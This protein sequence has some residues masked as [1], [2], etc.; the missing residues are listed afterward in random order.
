MTASSAPQFYAAGQYTPEQSIGYLM[1]KLISSIL[2]QADA[3][4]AQ[5]KLTYVQWLPL[6]KLLTCER[7]TLASLS[8]DL[9]VDPAALTRSISRL[10]AKGL[11]RR[12]RSTQ[13]RRVVHLSLTEEGRS[14]A[15]HVPG[16]L[17]D[18]LNGHLAGFERE[19]WQQLL[20]MLTRMLLNGEA[21]K[22]AAQTTP[23]TPKPSVS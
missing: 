18:V 14:V 16:V 17:A 9:S 20:Q 8:R 11:V 6:Y 21:M 10:E 13:D 22:S 15:A 1:N 7:S 23:A 5:Y 3:R 2:A 19:E 12:D 4:L